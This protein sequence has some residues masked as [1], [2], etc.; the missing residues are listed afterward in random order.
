MWSK[1]VAPLIIELSEKKRSTICK[2]RKNE[3]WVSQINTQNGLSI[4]HITQFT[5][6]WEM[7]ENVHLNHDTVDSP[8]CK[9]SNNGC[10]SAISAYKIQFIG[11]TTSSMPSWGLESLGSSK[12]QG[13]FL[14]DSSK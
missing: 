10:Y 7:L 8:V 2:A 1:G 14:A 9:F 13:V 5:K 11:L 12:V 3:F 4:N 6:V